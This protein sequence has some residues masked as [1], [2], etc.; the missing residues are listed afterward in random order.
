MKNK[1]GLWIL[2]LFIFMSIPFSYCEE[3]NNEVKEGKSGVFDFVESTPGNSAKDV[4]LDVQIKL[5]FNKNVV[6][7]T[8]K[9]NN[10]KCFSI[11][12]AKNKEI[13]IDVVFADDQIEPDKKRE[14][15][16]EPKKPLDENTTYTIH[17]SPKLQA[18]NGS[19]LDKDIFISFTTLSLQSNEDSSSPK[20]KP[21]EK[22][23][24]KPASTAPVQKQEE[25]T[26]DQEK[27]SDNISQDDADVSSSDFEN[28]K[29][30]TDSSKEEGDIGLESDTDLNDTDDDIEEQKDSDTTSKKYVWI[31][32]LGAVLILIFIF[33][34]KL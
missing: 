19:S 7:F 34:K 23:P 26:T 28:E 6:H 5:L 18:K 32:V 29:E 15:I 13:P 22:D 11:K 31:I 24:A 14:I 1:F 3:G 21:V 17:I 25:T 10:L 30:D 12:D 4:E 9:D 33:R 20:D 2:I 27:E 16:L 8:V